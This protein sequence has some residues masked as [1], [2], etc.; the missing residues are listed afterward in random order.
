MHVDFPHRNN[1]FVQPMFHSVWYSA[2]NK[3][4]KDSNKTNTQVDHT[5]P[6]PNFSQQLICMVLC[7]QIVVMY[8]CYYG[9]ILAM[10][11]SVC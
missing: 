8:V 4:L 10:S 5:V 11:D 2:V 9:F 1:C 6:L 3:Y 7:L